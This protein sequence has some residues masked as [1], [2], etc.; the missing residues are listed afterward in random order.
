MAITIELLAGL[1]NFAQDR[2]V[3]HEM[4]TETP[5][6]IKD[7]VSYVGHHVLV[8]GGDAFCSAD[9]VVPP[10]IIA[11]VNEQDVSLLGLDHS[12]LPGSRVTF[13]SMVHGG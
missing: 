13:L 3:L 11:M 10:G 1:E 5:V 6:T 12:I 4:P 8:S 2:A 9:D 7:V